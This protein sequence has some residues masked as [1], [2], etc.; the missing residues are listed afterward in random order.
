MLK[1][2]LVPKNSWGKNV[3][4]LITAMEWDIVRHECYRRAH[5]TCEICGNA[6]GVLIHC[7]EV[8][9]YELPCTQKLVG[10]QALC[11]RCHE[12]VHYGRTQTIGRE[13]EAKEWLMDVNGWNE[14][15]VSEHVHEAF[16]QWHRNN[17]VH[18]QLDISYLKEFMKGTP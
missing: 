15:Q 17:K 16:L 14:F 9:K 8:F 1:I 13:Q 2:D 7:H 4:W 5:Y 10:F 6:T 18:W 12:V 3:R 11:E